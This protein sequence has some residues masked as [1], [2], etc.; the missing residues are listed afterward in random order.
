MH[1]VWG[2]HD[3]RSSEVAAL[4][5]STHDLTKIHFSEAGVVGQAVLCHYAMRVGHTDAGRG[6]HARAHRRQN[7][8]FPPD[9]GER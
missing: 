9:P 2:N 3:K 4:F 8:V 6:P 5:E 7:R 1:L